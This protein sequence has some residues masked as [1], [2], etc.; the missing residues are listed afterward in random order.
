MHPICG[1]CKVVSEQCLG[2]DA[3][4]VRRLSTEPLSGASISMPGGMIYL[5]SH[6]PVLAVTVC[7]YIAGQKLAG[8][9][10]HESGNAR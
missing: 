8:M 1:D 3:E 4:M 10:C 7:R 6:D 2:A 5:D 9:R